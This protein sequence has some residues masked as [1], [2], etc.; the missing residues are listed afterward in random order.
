MVL[1]TGLTAEGAGV[2]VD[3]QLAGVELW[4]LQA[5]HLQTKAGDIVVGRPLD[6]T[7]WG[8]GGKKYLCL[9]V[10]TAVA[11]ISFTGQLQLGLEVVDPPEEDPT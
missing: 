10:L 2:T 4:P 3:L 6:L 11:H 9:T 8:C 7:V 1:A 5:V